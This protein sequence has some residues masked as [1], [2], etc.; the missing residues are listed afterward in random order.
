MAQTLVEKISAWTEGQYE[1][2]ALIAAIEASA[3]DAANHRQGFGEAVE[4]LTPE[5]SE[6]CADLVT[7]AFSLLEQLE[8]QLQDVI[9]GLE[10]EDRG[11]VIRSGDMINRI[12]FQ[13]NQTFGEFRNQALAAMGPTDIPNLNH[14][15]KMRHDYEEAPSEATKQ[16]LLE[17]IRVERLTSEQALGELEHSL[18]LPEIASL[19]H[20]FEVHLQSIISLESDVK[21]LGPETDFEGHFAALEMEFRELSDKIPAANLAQRTAGDTE[22]P[23]LN[24]LLN[25]IVQVETGMMGDG[26]LVEALQICEVSF[27]Q[28]MEKLKAAEPAIETVLAKEEIE[29]ALKS[30]DIF[31]EGVQATYKFL[32][33]REL[34][35]LQQASGYFREFAAVF[36]ACKAQLQE[37]EAQEGKAT[38]PRCAVVNE[39]G[40]QRCSSCGFPLPQNVGAVSKSTFQTKEAGDLGEEAVEDLLLTSN[41]VKLYEAVNGIADGSLGDEA[42]LG[43]VD[44]FESLVNAGVNSLPDEPTGDAAS[45]AVEGAYDAFDES[46]EHF[47]NGIEL[48]RS[49]IESRDEEDLK[50]AVR[51]IDQGAKTMTAASQAVAAGTP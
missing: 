2:D 49:F 14:L 34:V 19:K 26:P 24:Y 47:K 41:L 27:F 9:D 39:S 37:L 3:D 36:Q 1:K 30:F 31:G 25:M 15:L 50:E 28:S 45:K 35:W 13:L 10:A 33:L 12:S 7:F 21:E 4:A 5:Q 8:T 42:F 44:R 32:A 17:S 46:V 18:D 48:L 22:F 43:E 20:L 38:C 40:R 16:A 11:Q 6:R 23:D 51:F 29:K